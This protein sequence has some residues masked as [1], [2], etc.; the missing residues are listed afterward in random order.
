MATE[1]EQLELAIAALHAQRIL[2]G[3][4]LVDAALGPMRARLSTLAAEQELRYVTILFLDIVGSTALSQQLDPE[5]VHVAMDSAMQRYAA[6][7]TQHG[8]KVLKFA[9]D[10]VLAVF[11]AEVASEDDAERGVFA[12]LALLEESRHHQEWIERRFQH[13]GFNIRVGLHTGSVLLGGGVDA[14]NNIRGLPVNVAAR[15]EQSAPVG[16]LRISHDTYRLVR[17]VFDVVPQPPIEVKGVA[18]ALRT[19]LVLRGKPRALRRSSR[20]IEGIQTCMVARDTELQ[21]LQNAFLAIFTDPKYAQVHVVADAGLGKSRLLYEFKNWTA[22]CAKA[23]YFLQARAHANTRSQPYGLLRDTLAWRFQISDN[24]SLP[25]VKEKFEQAIIPVLAANGSMELATAHAHLLGHLLGIDYSASR[26]VRGIVDDGKQIRTRGYHAAAL[27]LREVAR[28]RRTPVLMVLD[29][30]HWADRETIDFLIY[31]VQINRDVPMLT[32]T[33][34]RPTTQ[35]PL[36]KWASITGAQPLELRAFDKH[37]SRLLAHELLK[38]LPQVPVVLREMLI[39]SADGNPFY[40]EELVKMLIDEG[41]ILTEP[42]SWRVQPEKLL[43]THVPPTLTGILQARLDRLQES[44][45]RGLQHASVIGSVFWDKALFWLS[46]DSGNCLA[47]L[48]QSRL[49]VPLADTSLDDTRTYA[50]A[51]QLLH[52]QT[53]DTLLKHAKMDMHARVAQWLTAQTGVRAKDYLA[54]TARHFEKA[55]DYASACDYYARAAEHAV[56]RHAH[57]GVFSF[58][59]QGLETLQF[60]KTTQEPHDRVQSLSMHWRLLDV[61][62]RTLD[63]EGRRDAQRIDIET[64]SEL[65]DALHNDQKRC[66][67]AARL[68]S[69]FMRTGDFVAMRDA[70]RD[71]VELAQKCGVPAMELRGQQR[72]AVALTY[73]GDTAAGSDLARAGLERSRSLGDRSLEALFLNAL[74]VIADSQSDRVAS[75]DW[76][77]QDLLI[78]RELGNQRNEA[79]AMTN[80]GSGWLA[81]GVHSVARRYLEGSL[82]LARAVG[83]RGTEPNTLTALSKLA[84]R[85]GDAAEARALAQA[86]LD[87]SNDVKNPDVAIIALWSLGRAHLALGQLTS[88]KLSFE[89]ACAKAEQSAGACDLDA[90]AGLAYIALRLGDLPTAVQVVNTLLLRSNEGETLDGAESA[91]LIRLFCWEVLVHANDVRALPVLESS[92]RKVM[93]AAHSISDDTIRS[94]FLQEIPEHVDTIVQWEKAIHAKP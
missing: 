29:D 64:L 66:D 3:D 18:Q 23:F 5:D 42:E 65:A 70:A 92:Y 86:A 20:G 93:E 47:T 7:I 91:C 49:V 45:R 55:G 75:L 17:G 33:L 53:Y 9:G 36:T 2:L 37:N 40:M 39:S 58:V 61:R 16:G 87:L 77:E 73:L 26:H 56:T 10:S 89:L 38:K 4:A 76:D 54:I 21:T 52:Q 41:A 59:S 8:G 35:E 27:F 78:N 32:V 71:C 51:H 79:I 25:A 31:L 57:D 80:L 94:Q 11:G 84:L 30:L 22:S 74:S 13:A 12:G 69:F 34:T 68:C 83:D 82:Q 67:V 14:E 19:Y 85:T 90:Q 50:F 88:A 46:P 48:V 1:R 15:M 24:D 72:L 6:V 43:A 60:L 44:Q 81:L 63:L 28:H 62:E